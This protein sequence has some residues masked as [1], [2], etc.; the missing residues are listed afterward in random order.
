MVSAIVVRRGTA[1]KHGDST[2]FPVEAI[3]ATVP[4]D[5][6]VGDIIGAVGD[7]ASINGKAA[8]V[9]RAIIP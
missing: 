4:M 8:A 5:V 3:K 9:S 7:T 6:V 2:A 1:T